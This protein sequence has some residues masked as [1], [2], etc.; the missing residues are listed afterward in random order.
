[1]L[2]VSLRYRVAW[3]LTLAA[4]RGSDRGVATDDQLGHPKTP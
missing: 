1:V 2:K 3:L 4:K